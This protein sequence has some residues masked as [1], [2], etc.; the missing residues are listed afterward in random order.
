MNDAT[1]NKFEVSRNLLENYDGLDPERFLAP[2]EGYGMN[3]EQPMDMGAL[4]QKFM[5]GKG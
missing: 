1:F 4:Q 5:Q 3:P 2:R